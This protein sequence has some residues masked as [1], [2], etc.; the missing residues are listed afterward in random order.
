MRRGAAGGRLPCNSGSKRPPWVWV[1][2][3]ARPGTGSHC[4]PPQ[5]PAH[6]RGSDGP[7]EPRC[8]F[9]R[10]ASDGRSEPRWPLRGGH[11]VA[12]MTTPSGIS[13]LRMMT[14][15]PSWIMKPPAGGL[16]GRRRVWARYGLRVCGSGEVA[17]A[18]L[19]DAA[20]C[21]GE[22][23]VDIHIGRC[24]AAEPCPAPAAPVPSGG[25]LPCKRLAPPA[26]SAGTAERNSSRKPRGATQT[27]ATQAAHSTWSAGTAE[28]TAAA[29]LE[30][31]ASQT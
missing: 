5:M 16:S 22:R 9:R 8:R 17:G 31:K 27:C 13:A 29:S 12:Q 24:P 21:K 20:A 23:A 25:L 11:L 1:L 10:P 26:S 15:M 7:S 3:V 28:R 18:V 2:G 14:T 30:C 4:K 6:A 19:G